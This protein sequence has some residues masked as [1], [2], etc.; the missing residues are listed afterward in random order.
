MF[1]LST[2]TAVLAGPDAKK[3]LDGLSIL[4]VFGTLVGDLT[5]AQAP[6][7]SPTWR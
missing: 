3:L 7:R 4:S 2:V 1:T 5:M 6:G